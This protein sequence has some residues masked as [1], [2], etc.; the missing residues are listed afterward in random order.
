MRFH[1]AHSFCAH[2]ILLVLLLVP[3]Q[4]AQAQTKPVERP[5]ITGI[6]HVGYF[7]SDLPKA[8]DFWHGLLG[9]DEYFSIRKPGTD[10]VRIAFI[11]LN[12]R[13]H[14][15]LFTDPPTAPPNR[16]SHVCFTVD[17]IEQMRTYLR[18][19][20]YPVKPG[21][22]SKTKAGD[23][24]FEIKDPDGTL[25]EFVQ[26]MPDGVEA[27]DQGKFLPPTRIADGIYHVGFL[28]GNSAKSMAFYEGVLGFKETWRGGRD[29]K[30]LSW[31]NLQVSDGQDYI[32]LML[33]SKLPPTYGTQN[34]VSLVAPDVQKAMQILE[35]RPAYK[36]YLTYAKPL[37]MHVGVNRKRQ[38]NL[39]DPNGTRVELMESR[40]ID[41]KPTP[42][43]MAPPPPAAH[44]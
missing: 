40:T 16:M 42:S 9:F 12:N 8:L 6:S 37:E 13:Q 22:G 41:G 2:V 23:Y 32:E 36:T 39:Y 28:V 1:S 24:A 3:A 21:N 26:S 30:Q 31:I 11:K 15:E 35:S 20:G 18:S 34:H 5:R 19:R 7:V 17:N 27:Q 43:S 10:Q 14:V 25:V 4:C 38:V 44:K 33:Y 29:P